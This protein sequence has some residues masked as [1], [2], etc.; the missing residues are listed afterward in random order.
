MNRTVQLGSERNRPTIVIL[1]IPG[2]SA[3]TEICCDSKVKCDCFSDDMLQTHMCFLVSFLGQA[4]SE[5]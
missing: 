1:L 2:W 4:I 3:N 5:V